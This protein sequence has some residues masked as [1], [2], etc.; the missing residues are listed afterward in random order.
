LSAD[1]FPLIESSADTDGWNYVVRVPDDSRFFEGHFAARS[2]LPAIAQLELI[3]RLY[4]LA[5]GERA[6]LRGIEIL[7]LLRPVGPGETLRVSLSRPDDDRRQRF[8]IRGADDIVSRGTLT[9]AEG[10]G[11]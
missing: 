3:T 2:V 9:W 6:S 11:R 7:R 5:I 8:T 1:V 4:R 10:A